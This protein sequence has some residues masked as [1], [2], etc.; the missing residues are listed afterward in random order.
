MPR[1]SLLAVGI[2][3]SVV[4]PAV[5]IRPILLANCS[6]NQRLPSG[7]TAMPHGPLWGVGTGNSMM[8]PVGVIRPILAAEY[9]VNQMLPSGPATR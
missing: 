3:N 7:P 5:V 2:A 8:A 6:V 1:G 9:S 4:V